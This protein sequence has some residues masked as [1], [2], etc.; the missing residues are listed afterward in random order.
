MSGLAIEVDRY[1]R[2]VAI[3]RPHIQMEEYLWNFQLNNSYE[4]VPVGL[5]GPSVGRLQPQCRS[6]PRSAAPSWAKYFEREQAQR[7]RAPIRR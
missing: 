1:G 3:N 2:R 4:Y 7:P 5:Y 6:C